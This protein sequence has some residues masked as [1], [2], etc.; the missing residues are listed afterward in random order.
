MELVLH[1][2]GVIFFERKFKMK[3]KVLNKL[4][5]KVSRP[6]SNSGSYVTIKDQYEVIKQDVLKLRNDLSK[7]YDLIR[8]LVDKKTSK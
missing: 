8:N 5:K 1:F 6:S 3:E 7:G 2:G 4:S